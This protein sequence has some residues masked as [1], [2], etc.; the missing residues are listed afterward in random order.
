MVFV[1]LFP[2]Y[3]LIA[4]PAFE[5]QPPSKGWSEV[6]RSLIQRSPWPWRSSR[7]LRT[8][9]S[10]PSSATTSTMPTTAD[11]IGTTDDASEPASSTGTRS[12]YSL[13]RPRG[14]RRMDGHRPTRVETEAVFGPEGLARDPQRRIRVARCEWPRRLPRPAPLRRR[15]RWTASMVI[16]SM[17]LTC[18]PGRWPRLGVRRAPVSSIPDDRRAGR[19]TRR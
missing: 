19:P 18:R 17:S 14:R 6:H 12:P 4:R 1:A 10:E 15:W 16:S 5:T 13:P 9:S 7:R 3:L 2:P 8:E 11:A